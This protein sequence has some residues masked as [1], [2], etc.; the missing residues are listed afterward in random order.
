MGR[1]LG[2]TT[3]VRLDA[4]IEILTLIAPATVR[5]VCYQ[6]FIRHLIASMAKNETNKVSRLLVG[7]RD[8]GDVAWNAIVDQTRAPEEANAWTDLQAYL[9]VM[10]AAYRRDRWQDQPERVQIWSEKGTVAGTLRPPS[11]TA[12]LRELDQRRAAILEAQAALRPIPRLPSLVLEDALGQWRR[13][14]RQSVT[15]GRSVLQRI[16]E[17]RIVFTPRPEGGADFAATTRY[18]ALFNGAVTPRPSFIPTEARGTEHL[19]A[20][21]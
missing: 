7:A 17:G 20:G 5:A 16:L 4:V 13:L 3:R 18:D 14:L 21:I 15:T 8:R 6:L 19:E 2:V 11:V 1:G 9:R 12:R 10:Q